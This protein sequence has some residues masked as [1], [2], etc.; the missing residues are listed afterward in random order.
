MLVP[1]YREVPSFEVS[2]MD[3]RK[4]MAEKI[5]AMVTRKKARDVYDIW[6][7][8]KRGVKPDTGLV[9]RKLKIYEMEYSREAFVESMSAKRGFWESDL[10]GLIIGPLPDFD[11]VRKEIINAL[12]TN[13]KKEKAPLSGDD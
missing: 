1:A 3:E 10:K 11:R 6:F 2:I 8:I 9:N 13:I 7:L 12:Q 4:I 5:R